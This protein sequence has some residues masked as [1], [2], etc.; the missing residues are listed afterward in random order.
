MACTSRKKGTEP[1]W[2][3]RDEDVA[4]DQ[5]EGKCSVAA[6]SGVKT[7]LHP[8]ASYN[9]VRHHLIEKGRGVGIRKVLR[10]GLRVR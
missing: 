7:L 6:P 5:G 3:H 10:Q 2:F 9:D 4:S 1:V 8:V